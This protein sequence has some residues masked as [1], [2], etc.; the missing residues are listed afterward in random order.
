MSNEDNKKPINPNR[1]TLIAVSNQAKEIKD[2]M[3]QT[4][5][6]V[7]QAEF[8]EAKTLNYFILN[9]VY[10]TN[11]ATEFNTFNQWKN[12]GRTIKK[13][14]KA[15]AIWGQPIYPKN[16][17]QVETET[18]GD[19]YKYFPICYLFSDLQLV[20]PEAKGYERPSEK[21]EINEPIDLT[22]IF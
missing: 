6:S 9:H 3:M 22:E 10:Q 20:E 12:Q 8:F 19:E 18:E 15:Y 17:P 13:G 21:V 14:A 1:E 7:A 16:K 5:V 11:G 4:A 2:L